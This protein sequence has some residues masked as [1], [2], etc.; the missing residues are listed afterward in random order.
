MSKVLE[1]QVGPNF[2]LE[3]KIEARGRVGS[4]QFRISYSGRTWLRKKIFSFPTTSN[5]NLTFLFLLTK[6]THPICREYPGIVSVVEVII[7]A[8]NIVVEDVLK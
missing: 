8:P 7:S 6:V 4:L 3:R 5:S 2:R 1:R